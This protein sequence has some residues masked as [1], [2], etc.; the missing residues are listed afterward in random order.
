[1]HRTAFGTMVE[2]QAFSYMRRCNVYVLTHGQT[3]D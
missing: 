2:L 1:M 3:L